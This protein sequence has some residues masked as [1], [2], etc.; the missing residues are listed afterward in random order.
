MC[1]LIGTLVDLKYSWILFVFTLCYNVTW[2]AF[3]ELY[4]LDAWLRGDVE[5][6]QCVPHTNPQWQPCFEKLDSFHSA[7]SISMDSQIIN[8]YGTREASVNCMDGLVLMMSQSVIESVLDV[9]MLG[10]IL[11]KIAKPKRR[12]P[13]LLFSQHCVV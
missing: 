5:H 3:A 10:Y 12:L 11:A 6:I 2:T 7:L 1:D 13:T 9:L 4:F 8:G